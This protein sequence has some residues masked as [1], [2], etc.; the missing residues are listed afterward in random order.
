MPPKLVSLV[1]KAIAE[2]DMIHEGDR[3]LI[4]LSGGKDSLSLLHV[5]TLLRKKAPKHFEVA[6]ATVDPQ[7]PEYDP[8][9]LK[10]YL[11]DLGVTYFYESQPIITQAREK[12]GADF[13]LCSYCSRMKR[14]ILYSCA[15][16]NGYNVLALGQHLDDLAESFMMSAFNNG[17]LRTMKANYVI[18]KGDLR[19]IRPLVFVRERLMKEFAQEAK[20]PVISE[21]CPACFA[22]PKERHRIKLLLASQEQIVPGLFSNLLRAM[23]PLMRGALEADHVKKSQAADDEDGPCPQGECATVFPQ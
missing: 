11:A 17:C 18:D 22:E 12:V 10:A 23:Q 3:V 19:V 5:L 7:T 21:N 16:R 13:S 1:G 6:A 8:S 9:P 2:F 20:L 14:G 4:G 15:R